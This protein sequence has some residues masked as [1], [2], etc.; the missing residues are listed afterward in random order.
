[1]DGNAS[2]RHDAVARAMQAHHHIWSAVSPFWSPH[3]AGEAATFRRG[4]VEMTGNCLDAICFTYED[5]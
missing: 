2:R 5:N 4:I 3:P 1:M